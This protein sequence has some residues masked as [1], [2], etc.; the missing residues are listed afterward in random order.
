MKERMFLGHHGLSSVCPSKHSVSPIPVPPPRACLS[1][2][3]SGAGQQGRARVQAGTPGGYGGAGRRVP[4]PAASCPHLHG[5]GCENAQPAPVSARF[6]SRS[7]WAALS[8]TDMCAGS[9]RPR[10]RKS[11]SRRV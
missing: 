8:V 9:M 6:R 1:F 2:V 3:T 10:L 4:G 5:P 7:G 11:H